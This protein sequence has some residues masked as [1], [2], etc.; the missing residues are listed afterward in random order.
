MTI[1]QN[2]LKSITRSK[3]RNM[4][5]GL[6]IISVTAACIIALTIE[7]SAKEIIKL[8]KEQFE[9]QGSIVLDRNLLRSNFSGSNEN[10][11]ALIATVPALTEAELVRYGE[12]EYV[13]E[14]T[15]NLTVDLNSN[16][17]IPV[18][19]DAEILTKEGGTGTQRAQFTLVGVTD[20]ATFDPFL[21]GDYKMLDGDA[22]SL[23]S[24]GNNILI[25]EELAIMNALIVGDFIQM[26]NPLNPDS[27]IDFTIS[28]VYSDES[29]AN[30]TSMNW[31]SK[32]ANQLITN[33]NYVLSVYESSIENSETPLIGTY[34]HTFYLTD[35]DKIDAFEAFIK[36][37][38]LNPYYML[39]TNASEL[40][41]IMQPLENLNNFTS[42]FFIL[43]LVV[44][45]TILLIINMINIRERK[46]EIGV[47]RAIGMKKGTVAKQFLIELSIVTLV[48]MVIGI[49][50]GQFLSEPIGNQLLRNEIELAKL[51]LETVEANLGNGSGS[52]AGIGTR[53]I[54]AFTSNES[55]EYIDALNTKLDNVVIIQ[56]MLIGLSI[57]LIGS[58][59]SIVTISR[60]EPLKIL[61][62][63]S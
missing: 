15:F 48:A 60:Y 47:L 23:N 27:T 8:Q 34:A 61:S 55:I 63:R 24:A 30:A 11:R 6:I 56:M 2:A 22:L 59:V 39:R 57:V 37:S 20:P 36:S 3:A 43:V 28:G 41:K 38:G 50:V 44:G 52:S 14:L 53:N 58:I 19:A 46:Y 62:T 9:L 13:R 7:K 45:S 40:D 54:G 16:T 4:L 1:I 26:V 51:K 49:S 25:N 29:E 21:N 10:M 17:V 5:I 31:F 18:G 35:Y 33:Y 32:S 42:M 12:S